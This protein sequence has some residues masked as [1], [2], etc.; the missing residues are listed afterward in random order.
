MR[1]ELNTNSQQQYNLEE[2]CR[3]L[4]RI[5]QTGS[6]QRGD[7]ADLA[8]VRD[9]LEGIMNDCIFFGECAVISVGGEPLFDDIMDD[10]EITINGYV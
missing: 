5:R 7:Y 2:L 1:V 10:Q 4:G 6:V 9:L 8:E 3:T